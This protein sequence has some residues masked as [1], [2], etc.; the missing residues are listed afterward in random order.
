MLNKFILALASSLVLSGAMMANETVMLT[1]K[2]FTDSDGLAT[3]TIL[4]PKK[5]KAEG[6]VW[7]ANPQMYF[8]VMPSQQIKIKSPDGLGIEI[9]PA[10]NCSDFRPSRSAMRMG[11]TRPEE[12]KSDNGTPVLYYP[13][14]LN[15]WKRHYTEKVIKNNPDKSVTD[16]KVIEVFEI[17]QLGNALKQMLAPVHR[18]IDEGNPLN[19]TMGMEQGY[20]CN[21]LGFRVE[22]KKD[23][24]LYEQLHVMATSYLTT[25][26][27]LGRQIFWSIAMDV[28]F[29]APK[30]KLEAN[31]PQMSLVAN[32]M[33]MTPKW[34]KTLFDMQR[35]MFTSDME[36]SRK[37]HQINM[38]TSRHIRET[39]NASWKR[40]Q[41]SQDES[42][43]RYINSIREVDVYSQ[44][45]QSYELPNSYDHVFG[46]G[47]GNFIMTNDAFYNPSSDLN[48]TGNW[49]S[50]EPSR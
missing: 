32:S 26:T 17:P 27:D 22:F 14:S 46:D 15:D 39:N 48:V 21:G 30:G 8:R 7:F 37:I 18:M 36:T 13:D 20:G 38:E 1:Q 4:F 31:L 9:G 42:H 35:K 11:A 28:A 40:Q 45:G 47:N 16:S 23:G 6:G 43:R 49:T 41:Q 44:G 33:R 34:Q 3:H 10:L 50:L 12:M 19:R 2:T 5:W 29:Y 25:D 24:I